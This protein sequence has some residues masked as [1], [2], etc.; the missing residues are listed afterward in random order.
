M[1]ADVDAQQDR[2]GPVIAG[3]FPRPG[4]GVEEEGRRQAA[5]RLRRLRE[6]QA[7]AGDPAGLCEPPAGLLALFQ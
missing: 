5:L 1:R 2:P 6:R 3:P 7:R 4:H